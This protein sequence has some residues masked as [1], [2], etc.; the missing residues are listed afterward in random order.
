MG[1]FPQHPPPRG[2]GAAGIRRARWPWHCQPHTPSTS[3]QT[4]EAIRYGSAPSTAGTEDLATGDAHYFDFVGN[5]RR[6]V[7]RVVAGRRGEEESSEF[8]VARR[9]DSWGTIATGAA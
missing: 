1:G 3:E 4:E 8:R 9:R 2:R 5:S 6:R 7:H